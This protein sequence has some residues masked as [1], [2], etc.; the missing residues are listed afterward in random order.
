MTIDEIPDLM[1]ELDKSVA[2]LFSNKKCAVDIDVREYIDEIRYNMPNEISNAKQMVYDRSQIIN[3]AKKEAENIIKRAEE[4]AKL[5]VNNEEIVKQAK[6]KAN[7]II[8]N[9]QNKDKEI[10]IAMN[11][12]IEEMLSQAE[13]VMNKNLNEIRQIKMLFVKQLKINNTTRL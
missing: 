3:G 6:E 2:I 8:L 1:D 5:M 9:A 4:R 11:E 10:R 13:E 12:R 7:D